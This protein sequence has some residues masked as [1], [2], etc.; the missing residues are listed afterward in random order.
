MLMVY[1]STVFLI[2]SDYQLTLRQQPKQ[3]RMCGVGEKGNIMLLCYSFMALKPSFVILAD[4]RP[5]D[6]PRK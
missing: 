3:S 5:I 4:R 1:N 2:C 6:P